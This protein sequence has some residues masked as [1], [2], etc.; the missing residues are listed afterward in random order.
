MSEEIAKLN[1]MDKDQLIQEVLR[2]RG[3]L[4]QAESVSEAPA[5]RA[6]REE[7]NSSIEFIFDVDVLEAK[8]LNIS[9][10]G[11][12]FTLDQALPVELR[13]ERQGRTYHYRARLVRT[14]GL[15]AGGF[16]M[17]L[18]FQGEVKLSE[19]PPPPGDDSPTV[20]F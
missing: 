12:A 20:Y 1:A 17:A 3:L 7:F 19:L 15:D 6:V 13:F 14:Q 18:E 8:G 4:R 10:T 11:V 16:L 2:L 9:T 5:Q